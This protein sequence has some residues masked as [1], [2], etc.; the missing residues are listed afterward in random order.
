[1]ENKKEEITEKQPI[2]E[3][4]NSQVFELG[5][6][7]NVI[8][9]YYVSAEQNDDGEEWKKGTPLEQDLIPKQIDAL[10]Q[11]CFEFQLKKLSK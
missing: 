6:L 1:M 8:L 7:V 9:D 4:Q 5:Y 2:G 11:K 3:I 10:V